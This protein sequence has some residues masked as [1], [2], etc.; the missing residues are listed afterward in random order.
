VNKCAKVDFDLCRPSDCHRTN[1]R[2]RAAE[3]CTHNLL[4]QEEPAET[5]MLISNTLCVGCGH[6]VRDC[7]FGAIEIVT[8]SG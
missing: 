5:P 8:G 4:E 7:P 6:C 2:C 3:A 1:G